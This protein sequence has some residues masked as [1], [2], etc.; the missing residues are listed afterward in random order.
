[1]A[2]EALTP[3]KRFA[4]AATFTRFPLHLAW[5]MTIHKSQ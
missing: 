1:M 5:A 2:D 4:A 3:E